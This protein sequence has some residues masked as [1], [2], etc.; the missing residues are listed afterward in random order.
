[1]QILTKEVR[2]GL[3]RLVRLHYSRIGSFR[4]RTGSG[5]PGSDSCDQIPPNWIRSIHHCHHAHPAIVFRGNEP[6]HCFQ[7][8]RP[9]RCYEWTIL[10]WRH[11]WFVLLWLDV[12]DIW[13]EDLRHIGALLILISSALLTVA[14]NMGMFIT[15]RFF[16]GWGCFQL[17]ATVPL[18]IAEIAP[19][20][21]RG[22]LVDIHPVMV[23]FGYTCASY[24]GIGF[25]YYTGGGKNT[26]GEAQWA[27][28]WFSQP[29]SLVE[30]TGFPSRPASFYL[31]IVSRRR[32]LLFI[33]CTRTPRILP[34]SLPKESS[35]RCG[36]RSSS[37]C[38]CHLHHYSQLHTDPPQS[39]HPKTG[40]HHHV[41]DL[42]ADELGRDR[43]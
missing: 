14:V 3:T 22:I 6:C 9:N 28:R 8:R 36:N 34:M 19:P 41:L 25:Y 24:V 27:C 33:G 16:T 26:P 40:L 23:N 21:I 20:K 37:I 2:F 1:M 15:F 4:E 39:I 12:Y 17:L 5:Q 29:Y 13:Q 35:I 31:R 11:L 43:D 32:G 10:H 38:P 42:R 18:W 7:R 30:C